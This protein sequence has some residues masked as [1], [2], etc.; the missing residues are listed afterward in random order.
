M[1]TKPFRTFASYLAA[2][3]YLGRDTRT[4]RKYEGVL[5]AIDKSLPSRRAKLQSCKICGNQFKSAENRNG[6]CP[7]CSQAG[8]GRQT[9]AAIIAQRYQRQS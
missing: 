3:E 9:Q 2:A 7:L 6:Y 5:F 4:I 8:K 1:L